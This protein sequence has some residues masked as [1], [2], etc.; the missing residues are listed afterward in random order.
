MPNHVKYSTSP[1]TLALKKGNFHIRPIKSGPTSGTGFWSGINPPG[2]GYVVYLNKASAGPAVYVA[3]NDVGLVAI[4]NLVAGASYT[5]AAQCLS[6]YAGQ[7]DKM[8]LNKCYPAI[9]TDGL[10][11]NMEPGFTASYPTTG[12]AI[13]D[14][15]QSGF[16]GE[17]VNGAAWN[18]GGWVVLDGVDD[19]IDVPWGQSLNPGTSSFTIECLIYQKDA[20]ANGIV[21]ARGT[22]LHGFLCILNYSSAGYLGF[23]LNTTNDGNQN[24]YSSSVATFSDV[25]RW[26]HVVVVV[27]R[28]AE[29]ITYYKNGIAQGTPSSVT[30]GGTI[31]PGSGYRYN[32]GGDRGGPEANANFSS[33]R[34]YNRILSPSEILQNC[35]QGTIVTQNIGGMYDAGNLVS[36]MPSATP[37]YYMSGTN[38]NLDGALQNGVTYNTGFGG[39]WSFDGSNDRILLNGS[40]TNAWVLNANTNWTVTAWIRTTTSV[41]NTLGAGPIFTNSSGGPVYSSMC[42]NNGKATYWHYNGTWLQKQGTI[43]VNDGK[44]YMIT[45]V[46]RSNSTMDI[47]VN[48]TLDASNV[49]SALSSTNY[50]DIIGASWTAYYN[51]DI[52]SLQINTTAFTQA[53]VNTNFKAQRY[54]FGI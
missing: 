22:N 44:W 34:Q 46:N 25:D 33:Y 9:V 48:N 8:A 40:T 17:F 41:G 51:G 23:F 52:A 54:R 26:M 12:N 42:V 3:A 14:L 20:G 29:T 16:Y 35:Y 24:I 5:T 38:T 11:L 18:S 13:Y 19:Y 4:T 27:N 1:Q 15:S 7:S 43:T 49:S 47:Y 45:W 2:G 37:V 32:I 36:F 6:Y 30:S 31:D 50:L 10:V 28:T 39:Y 53:Q 21:E